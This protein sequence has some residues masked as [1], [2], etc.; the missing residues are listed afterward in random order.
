ML[1]SM[2]DYT[3]DR[4]LVLKSRLS[5]SPP[6]RSIAWLLWSGTWDH[7]VGS[8]WYVFVRDLLLSCSWRT[9]WVVIYSRLNK[10]YQQGWLQW[11]HLQKNVRVGLGC[12]LLTGISCWTKLSN[13]ILRLI[14]WGWV[15][16][17]N[18]FL[19]SRRIFYFLNLFRQTFSLG[20]LSCRRGTR[21]M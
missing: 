9:S 15:D 16:H 3:S 11:D 14:F 21:L 18:H 17:M 2:Q 20:V 7:W 4:R 13:T 8:F 5:T 1:A 6:R 12:G 10:R 19:C